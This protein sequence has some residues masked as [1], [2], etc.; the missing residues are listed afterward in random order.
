MANLDSLIRVTVTDAANPFLQVT[1]YSMRQYETNN[2]WMSIIP[3]YRVF[4][5]LNYDDGVNVSSEDFIE[6]ERIN[7]SHIS[8]CIRK[9]P[10]VPWLYT[11]M[12]DERTVRYIRLGIDNTLVKRTDDTIAF[13]IMKECLT[14][15]ECG[16]YAR[17]DRTSCGHHRF[18]INCVLYHDNNCE[19]RKALQPV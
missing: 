13:S 15:Q 17:Y 19:A 14:C 16:S 10:Q 8:H 11:E 12:V 5:R 2:G 18:C 7:E 6:A 9:K 4:Y 3:F 1:T